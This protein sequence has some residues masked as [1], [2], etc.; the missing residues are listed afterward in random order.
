VLIPFAMKLDSLKL[1]RKNPLASG[2]DLASTRITSEI[3]NFVNVNGIT[4]TEQFP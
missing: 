2:N 4:T 3:L 1:S